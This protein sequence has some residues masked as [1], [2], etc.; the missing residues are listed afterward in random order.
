MSIRAISVTSIHPHG[1]RPRVL[2]ILWLCFAISLEL[3][4]VIGAGIWLAGNSWPR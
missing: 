1:M 4:T 3:G 2:D